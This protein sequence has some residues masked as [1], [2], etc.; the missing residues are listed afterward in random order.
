MVQQ[1]PCQASHSFFQN[2]DCRYFPCHSG[3]DP[4]C[5]NCLFC[6]CPLYFLDECCGDFE[7]LGAIKDC[8]KCL[9]PHGA[10]G[11]ERTVGLLKEEFEKRRK[12]HREG[13]VEG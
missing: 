7:M 3:A 4:A 2:R 10:G 13:Q 8:S 9:K 1:S 5:F 12:K 11:Y 6:Y